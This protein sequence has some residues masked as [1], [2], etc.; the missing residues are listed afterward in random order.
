MGNKN[1]TPL[2]LYEDKPYTLE[3]FKNE[4]PR[5]MTLHI[6]SNNKNSCISFVKILTGEKKIFKKSDELLEKDINKK[7]NLFSFMNY[8][9]Y[10]S[11]DIMMNI[12]IDKVESEEKSEFSEVVIVLPNEDINNQIIKI[13]EK[14]NDSDILNTDTYYTPFFIFCS[15]N[16]VDLNGFISSKTF[17]YKIMNEGSLN[18]KKNQIIDKRKWRW[19]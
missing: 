15:P 6:L 18:I 12:L 9:I 4:T 7:I 17:Y 16:N 10:D 8:K 3:Q 11:A 1:P 2:P 19:K 13:K 5:K 14:M